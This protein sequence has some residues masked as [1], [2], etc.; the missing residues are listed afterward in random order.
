MI[1]GAAVK[2]GNDVYTAPAGGGICQHRAGFTKTRHC[3]VY[4]NNR[5]IHERAVA[6]ERPEQGFVT[7]SGEFL[8][9]EQA[10]RYAFE[11]GQIDKLT[12]CLFSEDLW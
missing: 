5:V 8:N 4:N 12:D 2:V 7:D 3:C 10:G 6:G 11:R 9:R 1:T